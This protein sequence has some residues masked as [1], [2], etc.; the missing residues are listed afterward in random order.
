[1]SEPQPYEVGWGK[2][3]KERV[4]VGNLTPGGVS[5]MHIV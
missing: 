5:A 3:P 4:K 2:L 1:M